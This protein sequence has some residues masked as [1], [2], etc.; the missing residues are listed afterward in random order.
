MEECGSPRWMW[1]ATRKCGSKIGK[2]NWLYMRRTGSR[3][4]EG[5]NP[6]FE[7]CTYLAQF[8]QAIQK[9]VEAQQGL[10]VSG[11]TVEE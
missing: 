5:G 10:S 11:V 8:M 1:N 9:G 2:H 7:L 4:E 6:I 3:R